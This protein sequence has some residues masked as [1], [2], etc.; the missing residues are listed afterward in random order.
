MTDYVGENADRLVTIELRSS[1]F[2]RDVIRPLHEAS[3]RQL[4]ESSI[5]GAAARALRERIG[6]GDVVFILTGSGYP[7]A[8]PKGENDGPPGG[9]HLAHALF[10]GLGAVPV[11]VCEARHVDP[12][13]ASSQAAGLMI[14][15]FEHAKGV[16]LGASIAAIPDGADVDT[17]ITD[18]LDEYDPKAIISIEKVGPG[19][20]GHLHGITGQPATDGGAMWGFTD[21]SGL[22]TQA[23]ERGVLSIGVGDG[24]NE[25]GFAN[26]SEEV[27]AVAPHGAAICC[28]VGVDILFPATCSNWGAYAIEAVL[29]ADLGRPELM[30][31]PQMEQ[32]VLQACLD[33]GGVE[34][35]D[36]STKFLLDG[37]SGTASMALVELLGELV[38]KSVEA[39]YRGPAH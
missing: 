20:N 1:S 3:L 28:T 34:A 29:A 17:W 33:A 12:I 31:T 7:P 21:I 13:V 5:S 37:F 24:G 26:L 4:G 32:R 15:P 18:V 23:R 35:V 9:A 2:P 8:M 11:F 19:E 6:P 14:H 25:I 27:A 22:V 38:R 10:R 16:G 39:P 30:H 36:C